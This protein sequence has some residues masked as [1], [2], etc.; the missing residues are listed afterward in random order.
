MLTLTHSK[1]LQHTV[2][3]RN[4][5]QH[6]ARAF[7]CGGEVDVLQSQLYNDIFK[8]QVYSGNVHLI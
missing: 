7:E 8:S 1:T 6:T 5:L 4:T 2:I 3:H